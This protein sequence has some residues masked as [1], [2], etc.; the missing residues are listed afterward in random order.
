[1]LDY[2]GAPYVHR[3]SAH[4]LAP[5][6]MEMERSLVGVRLQLAKRYARVNDLNRVIYEG[7]NARL[8]IIAAGTAAHDVRGALIDLGLGEQAPVRVLQLGMLYPLD[9]EIVRD[10]AIGIDELVVVEEKG[11]FLERLV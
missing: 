6:S 1:T 8:G 5:Q 11:P 4:L 10:F 9:E 3:P 2:D 7:P